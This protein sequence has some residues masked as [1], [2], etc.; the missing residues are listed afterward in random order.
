MLRLRHA[1]W[2]GAI[3]H[4]D[5]ERNWRQGW[6]IGDDSDPDYS[7]LPSCSAWADSLAAVDTVRSSKPG[8][9]I[10]RTRAFRRVRNSPDT[11]IWCAV[12]PPSI[13]TGSINSLRRSVIAA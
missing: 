4:A 7:V 11:F 6:G 3:R 12:L 5:R 10:R 9:P 8:L 2:G 1:G 13:R